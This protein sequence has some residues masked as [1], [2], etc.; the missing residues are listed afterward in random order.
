M[1]L[2]PLCQKPSLA[3]YAALFSIFEEA[4]TTENGKNDTELYG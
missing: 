4:S 2:E 1:T 3:E